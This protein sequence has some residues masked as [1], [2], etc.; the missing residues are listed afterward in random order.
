MG[1]GRALVQHASDARHKDLLLTCLLT[2]DHFATHLQ[3][4]FAARL[5]DGSVVA[6]GDANNGGFIPP[7][8]VSEYPPCLNVGLGGGSVTKLCS[9]LAAARGTFLP[10][11][12]PTYLLTHRSRRRCWAALSPSMPTRGLSSPSPPTVAS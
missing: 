4:A 5:E 6:W 3:Y 10:T 12:L 7:A 9:A 2:T 11:H 1:F 8:K